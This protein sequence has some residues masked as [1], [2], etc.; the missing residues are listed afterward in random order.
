MKRKSKK[1]SQRSRWSL[2][3]SVRVCC[4]LTVWA[5]VVYSSLGGPWRNLKL[6]HNSRHAVD[7]LHG[8]FWS[9]AYGL[10]D[11]ILSVFGP[12]LEKSYAMLGL[13]WSGT[14]FGTAT[15]DPILV[16]SHTVRNGEFLTPLWLAVIF[17]VTLALLLGKVFCS[18]I[19]PMRFL[20]Q[21][22]QS[23]RNALLYFKLPL[24]FY[25]SS[26]RFGGPI[27][28]GGLLAVSFGGIA[29]WH[30]VL[31]YAGA[32]TAVFLLISTGVGA[33]MLIAPAI[34]W[35]IDLLIAPGFFCKN[36]CPQGFLLET[37]GRWSPFQVRGNSQIPCPSGCDQCRRSCPY[38]LFPKEETHN[39][40]CDKC[41]ICVTRCP[42]NRLARN[43]RLRPHRESL[44]IILLLSLFTISLQPI[45]FSDG[46][47][48][49]LAHHNKG[50]PHYGY[51]ENY[52]QVPTEEYIR[53]DNDWEIGATVF[54]FQ[55]LDRRTADTPN[56]VKIYLYLYNLKDDYSYSGPVDFQI[57]GESGTV[58]EF[59]R[60][61][62]DQEQIYMSREIM[63]S[64]G[65]YQI[66]ARIQT[67]QGPQETRL[68]FYV[69]ISHGLNWVLIGGILLPVACVF[70]LALLG[71]KRKARHM[72]IRSKAEVYTSSS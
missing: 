26:M 59:S 7:L 25:Q 68:E 65:Y 5:F 8:K 15:A 37:I 40:A 60:S 57:V 32:V 49:A 69:D 9:V 6:A 66:I 67:P 17:P 11:D 33:Y 48:D 36:L 21:I 55:G 71:Q 61:A 46:T 54:N 38:G 24:P 39:P 28:I 34:L 13:P 50:L 2:G 10:N 1:P 19:C 16:L 64:S 27:L 72:A 18:Y 52:P 51:F 41:G 56:D 63:P 20:F 47:H 14:L 70:A 3:Q 35:L 29:L 22:G 4:Q 31:P 43:V 42:A 45:I 58:S 44:P 62:P 53:I 30:F 23:I 12:P